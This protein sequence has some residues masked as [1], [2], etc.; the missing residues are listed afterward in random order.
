MF[1][2]LDIRVDKA[3]QFKA[4]KL[5]A[6][7]DVQNVYNH[8]NV[9]GVSYNYNSTRSTFATGLPILPSLGLRGEL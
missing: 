6:Y 7:L 8:G 4:W 5:G 1:H 3:W 2:Q 9:E